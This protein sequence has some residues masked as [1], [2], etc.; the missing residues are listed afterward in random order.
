VTAPKGATNLVK[1]AHVACDGGEGIL[2]LKGG[3][4]RLSNMF[5][6]IILHGWMCQ[7]QG[8]QEGKNTH[9]RRPIE[10]S[11]MRAG[12]I[13]ARLRKLAGRAGR[14]GGAEGGAGLGEKDDIESGRHNKKADKRRQ[15]GGYG[16]QRAQD[17]RGMRK[18]R[19]DGRSSNRVRIN[20]G[21]E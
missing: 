20:K 3:G 11:P 5:N 15:R 6:K 18:E 16:S 10:H 8:R 12:V 17:N 13:F 7:R 4:V 19:R 2:I 9:R 1:F 14:R 21:P